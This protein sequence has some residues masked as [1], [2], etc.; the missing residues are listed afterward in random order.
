MG[1]PLTN[2][3]KEEKLHQIQFEIGEIKFSIKNILLEIDGKK[4]EGFDAWMAKV[5]N[6]KANK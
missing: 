1:R 5:F 6:R 2:M 4:L 3:T